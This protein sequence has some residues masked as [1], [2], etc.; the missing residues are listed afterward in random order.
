MK[1]Y[2]ISIDK[3]LENFF[4][5][6]RIIKKAISLKKL[7]INFLNL[8]N[9]SD[10]EKIDDYQ[11]GG[12][13][14]MVLKVKPIINVLE[15]LKEKEKINSK[16]TLTLLLSPQGKLFNQKI[17]FQWI[18]NYDIIILFCGYYEGF[19]E[20]ILKFID[21]EIS[22]GDYILSN[23]EIAALVIC[24][25]LTRFLPNIIKEESLIND[26]LMN[27]LLDYPVYTTPR[28]FNNEKVPNVLLKGNHQ[29]IED[30]R[31]KQSLINTLTKR[32]ELLSKLKL[33][34][35]NWESILFKKKE[36]NK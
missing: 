13:K 31:K 17:A 19:D 20:R 16:K 35:E 33:K 32:P 34:K 1:L 9:F 10:N 29:E 22:I 18:K 11:Y 2:I 23:G 5:K 24:D 7:E 14:G 25:V 28:N 6:N 26:S 36:K 12:G 8:R 27:G 30:W 4:F 21:Q 15:F 3:D